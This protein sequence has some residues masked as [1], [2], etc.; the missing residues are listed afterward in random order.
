LG[1]QGNVSS[2][3]GQ[4]ATRIIV[5]C[6]LILE[7]IIIA[8]QHCLSLYLSAIH[9]FPRFLFLFGEIFIKLTLGVWTYDI[10]YEKISKF[11]FWVN[12][13]GYHKEF[14]KNKTKNIA[15]LFV[16]QSISRYLNI[17]FKWGAY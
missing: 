16:I 13:E 6:I 3:W 2:K 15:N 5:I 1:K 14:K 9:G 11:Y 4:E 7:A 8:L 17:T 10:T 12:I